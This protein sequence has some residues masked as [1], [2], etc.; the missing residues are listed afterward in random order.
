MGTSERFHE[1]F[2]RK[3]NVK[4]GSARSFG[5]VF[6]VVFAIIALWPLWDGNAPRIWASVVAVVFASVAVVRP[7]LLEP[8]NRVW[9]RFG[10]LLHRIVSPVVMGLIFFL[11]VTPTGLVMRLLGKRP[12]P[13]HFEERVSYW[14]ERQPPGPTP[15]SIKNQF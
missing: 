8:L 9:L 5:I 6:A 15:D 7:Q 11:A 3:Q 14:I 1:S 12:I 2:G 4:K 10:E 13:L